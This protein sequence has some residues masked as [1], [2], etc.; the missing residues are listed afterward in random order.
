MTRLR[1][2]RNQKR[3]S[4]TKRT[5]QK[6]Q[7]ESVR[8]TRIGLK[9]TRTIVGTIFKNLHAKR[10]ES[11]ANYS[12][13]TMHASS[14]AIQAIGAAYASVAE[15]QPKHGVKQVDRYL[16]NKGIDIEALTPEWAKYVLGPRT[17]VNIIVD[18]TDFEPDDHTT[19]YAAVV[20][21]HGRATPL[22][23]KTYKKSTLTDGARTAAEHALIER[24]GLAIAPEVSI[25]L[26]A[27]RGFGSRELYELLTTL[28]W[29]YIIRFRSSIIVEHGDKSMSAKQWLSASGRARKLTGASVTRDKYQVGA[30][31]IVQRKGMKGAWC[32][33]TNR[34]NM[35]ASAIIKLYGRRFTI[36]ETFRD[37][38][39]LRFGRGLH[40]THIRSAARRDRM[41]MLLAVAHALLTLLGAAS[42]R[43]GLDAY[44]KVN[45]VKRRTHSLI[46]QGS[47]WYSCLSTMRED[48]YERLITA[49]DD[50]LAE[51]AQMTDILG[52]I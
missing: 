38:K 2:T 45:T 48:W 30:V 3:Q 10:V 14:V 29:D 37:Q 42:E 35:S 39:D 33:A 40:A 28:G 22:A 15:I 1:T 7:R 32:L 20:T 23:W 16:S 49:F 50:V 52:K 12:V 47:Y 24:L 43:S 25:T 27:D 13:G 5:K 18:W 26:V 36:E 46:R 17:A 8:A 19:L 6:R 9:G 4:R 21:N 34:A 44:L 41:L 31:V 11:L 51:H